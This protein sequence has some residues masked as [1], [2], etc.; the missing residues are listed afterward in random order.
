[1]DIRNFLIISLCFALLQFSCTRNNNENKVEVAGVTSPE[2]S[3]NGT[4][5]FSMEAPDSH[6]ENEIDFQSWPDIQVPG[7]C[8]MQGFAIKHDQPYVYKYEVEVPADYEGKEIFIDFHGVYSYARVWI[9]G[10]FIREHFGG[11][12]KWSCNITDHVI[13]SQ[14][15]ILTVEIVDRVDDISY[16]SGYAKHQIGGILRDVVL[17]ALP[18]QNF[19]RL[20]FETYLDD[21][22][23][24]AELKVFYELSKKIPAKLEI[25]LLDGQGKM[26]V[27]TTEITNTNTGEVS[28]PVKNPLKWDAEHP[29]LYTVITTLIEGGREI[30]SIPDRIGFREVEVV[31]NKLLVNGMPVKLRGACRHDIHPLLGRMTSPEYDKKDVLLAKEANMNFIRTSHY[32]PSDAFLNYCDEYGIYVEDETAVCFVG[33]H[34]TFDYQATGAS[35]NKSE[36]TDRYLS[37]L[38]EMVDHHRDH[39]SVIIWSIGNE[40][41]FGSNFIASYRWVKNN[42]STRPVIYSYPGPVPDSVRNY[43]ILSMHYPDWKG[44]L[45]QYKKVTKDFS[46]DAMPVLFDEWAHVA[47]YNNPTLRYDPNVRNFWGE[48]LDLMWDKLFESDGGLGGAIWCMIDETFMLPEDL[49]GY[50]QWWGKLDPNIIPATYMGPTVGYGEWGIIDTWRRKK[51]EFWATKKA[52]SPARIMVKQVDDFT[53]GQDLKLPVHNRFDHTNFN[54]LRISYAYGES[55]GWLEP[56]NLEPHEKGQLMLPAQ[57]WE[58]GSELT[59]SFFSNNEDLFDTYNIRIGSP[60]TI[61]PEVKKGKMEIEEDNEFIKVVG[62]DFHLKVNKKTGLF[63]HIVSNEDTL[64]KSGPYINFRIPGQRIQYSTIVMDDY[65]QH[66]KCEKLN[67]AIEEEVLNLHTVGNYDSIQAEFNIQVDKGGLISFSYDVTNAPENKGVQEAGLKFVM[68]NQFNQLSWKRKA[69]FTAYPEYDI[70]VPEGKVNLKENVS[71]EYR[72][73][74]THPWGMDNKNFYYHGLEKEFLYANTTRSLKE[75]IYAYKLSSANSNVSVLSNGTQAGRFD[76][77]DGKNILIINDQW[78]YQSLL[79]GNYMKMIKSSDTF[80]GKVMIKLNSTEF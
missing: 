3:L 68:G 56:I 45:N 6:W 12:T 18:K 5:K 48:S 38:E 61:L 32:P 62:Q 22:Y 19:T 64:I 69:Y 66:W 36:Y 35:Q 14:K 10:N 15:A 40:N 26:V 42:D 46:Y 13:P 54:E 57:Q 50:N 44:D 74:P 29:Y 9:N 80:G 72:R 2:I 17:K 20:Y 30:L 11:F 21:K 43:E 70:G 78:D 1:M 71:M 55:S 23:E 63:H 67:Y 16:G 47:C 28:I 60:K 7:E 79:W 27:N 77:L 73:E 58:S 31:G 75:N 4:W 41:V 33:S 51:P 76:N 24:N 65:A 8:Q 34:R 37:Q 25:K 53:T 39:P 49:E 59:I 52:Y